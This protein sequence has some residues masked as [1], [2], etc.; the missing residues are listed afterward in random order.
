MACSVK[1][2]G[3]SA[4]SSV[5]NIASGT[6]LGHIAALTTLSSILMCDDP[7]LTGGTHFGTAHFGEDKYDPGT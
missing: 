2:L 1:L 5:G 6:I 3:M 4:P 7:V